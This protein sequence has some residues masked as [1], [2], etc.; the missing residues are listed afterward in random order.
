MTF[1]LP[2]VPFEQ[3]MLAE[4]VSAY[5][6]AFVLEVRLSG[7]LERSTLETSWQAALNRHPL[8]RARL[9]KIKRQ[10]QWID[11]PDDAPRIDWAEPD[12]PLEFAG[13][14]LIDLE[15]EPGVRLWVRADEEAARLVFQF[16]HS[17]CD[18]V[19]GLQFIGDLLA[20]YANQ[21]VPVDAAH[22]L[23]LLDN[24]LL[25]E[26]GSFGLKTPKLKELIRDVRYIISDAF[27][28]VARRSIPVS[29]PRTT[30]AADD[31][32]SAAP[33]KKALAPF[34]GLES[35]TYGSEELRPLRQA[36]RQTGAS[37]NDLL[38]C[39]F[40]QALIEWNVQ[41]GETPLGWLRLNVPTNLRRREDERMP[42]ANVMSFTFVDRHTRECPN[43][44][45]LLESIRLETEAIRH[46]RLG[47]CFIAQVGLLGAIPGG[48]QMFLRDGQC[49]AT[50]VLTNVG[51][52]SRR[53]NVRLP[54]LRDKL[55]VG[56]LVLENI[57][58]SP[59]LRSLTRAGVGVTTYGGKLTLTLVCDRHFFTQQQTRQLLDLYVARIDRVV[60]ELSATA[61]SSASAC[62]TAS[63][64]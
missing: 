14:E 47:L 28:L 6:R 52:P 63:S 26:R 42:A 29:L 54:R 50:A 45:A 5:P 30:P 12:A 21:Q 41:S 64:G 51:D 8:L 25:A 20:I 38:M 56:N 1:P 62:V 33:P 34:P 35:Y 4:N 44:R 3:Y 43:T 57:A 48:L 18:G 49:L 10:W 46:W 60:A 15:R 2:L 16:H 58:G 22:A 7:K 23:P 53:F 13:A 55:L 40:F 39:C 24:E 61:V 37:L 19:G 17:C 36:A 59:P 32:N 9:A 27:R 11:F 31:R